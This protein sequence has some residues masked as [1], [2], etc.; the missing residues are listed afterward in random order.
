MAPEAGGEAAVW[1]YAVDVF[2]GRATLER[3]RV[4]KQTDKRVTTERS[5]LAFYCRTHHDPQEC[6]FTPESAWQAFLRATE[7]RLERAKAE[8]EREH[9]LLIRAHKALVTREWEQE[10]AEGATPVEGAR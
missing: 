3:A 5:G 7:K 10:R 1:I 6:H 4:I 2:D 8:T 9:L